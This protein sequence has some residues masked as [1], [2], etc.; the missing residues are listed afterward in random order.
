MPRSATSR[1]CVACRPTRSSPTA[2]RT[3]RRPNRRKWH[4]RPNLRVVA[5]KLPQRELQRGG[6]MRVRLVIAAELREQLAECD[7]R[8]PVIVQCETRLEIRLRLA[9]QL[10]ALAQAAERVEQR[11]I[12]VVRDEPRSEEH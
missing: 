9:P 6:E 3:P 2:S 5:R 10:L 11:R 4:L 1:R 12:L 8:P 7:V